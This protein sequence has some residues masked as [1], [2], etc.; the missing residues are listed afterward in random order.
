[1]FCYY[2]LSQHPVTYIIASEYDRFCLLRVPLYK[3]WCFTS[4][5][6]MNVFTCHRTT[7]FLAIGLSLS[8]HEPSRQILS[9]GGCVFLVFS[10]LCSACSSFF[11]LS[12]YDSQLWSPVPRVN[13]VVTFSCLA[14]LPII[15]THSME[16]HT[17]VG[18]W[19]AFRGTRALAFGPFWSARVLPT[20]RPECVRRNSYPAC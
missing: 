3:T 16:I 5:A 2:S 8:C 14:P 7:W 6:H 9:D 17:V 1:M 15:L 13:A 4:H 12:S 18:V 19:L 20:Q 11:P 10:F